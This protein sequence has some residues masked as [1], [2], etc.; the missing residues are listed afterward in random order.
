MNPL[1]FRPGGRPLT[2]APRLSAV[3]VGLALLW[4]RPSWSEWQTFSTRDGLAGDVVAALVEDRSGNL[5][6]GTRGGVSRYDGASWRTYT[7]ADGLA[8]NDVLAVLEDRSGNLWF[9]G[10]VNFIGASRYDGVSWRTY[11]RAD[12]FPGES[13]LAMLE[14][15]SG[16][17][18]FGTFGGGA[19][20]YDGV[21]WRTYTPADG[22]ATWF[23]SAIVEDRSSNLWFGTDSGV[24][25]YDGTSW[26]T[27]TTADGLAGN[28]I[29]SALV[30]HSGNVWFGSYHGGVSRWNG[31][32]WQTYTT[33]D[34]LPESP[35]YAIFEDRSGIL[36]FG[37]SDGL[38]RYDGVSWRTYTSPTVLVSVHAMIEDQSGN[39]WFGGNGG[40]IRYDGA[41][42]RTYTTS[43]GLPGN[44]V[45]AMLVDR[46][47]NLW[48]GTRG[49]VSRY[50][51]ASWRTYTTADGLASDYVGSMLEDHSGN[52][53]FGT[54]S[55]VSRYDGA[56]WRT[57]TTAD[58]LLGNDVSAM[59]ED[60]SG[61]LWF[62]YNSPFGAVTRWDGVSWRTYRNADGLAGV[63]LHAM[64]QDRSGNIWFATNAG[65]TRYDGTS[66]RTFTADDGLATNSVW[67]ILEDHSGNLWFG[68]ELG[69][70]RYDGVSWRTY[71]T[72]DGLAGVTVLAL[73]EDRSGTLWVAD[74]YFGV[75]R[76]DGVAWRALT[77]ADGLANNFVSSIVEDRF[78]NVWFGT[79][80]GGASAHAPDRVAPRAV[81]VVRP[82]PVAATRTLTLGFL[83]GFGESGVEFSNAFDGGSW[84]PWSAINTWT[85]E[86]M[87]D[88]SH[89]FVV[90]SR[91][92]FN[93][94]DPRP[95]QITFEVDAT[96]PSPVITAPVF[97][98]AIRDSAIIL[99]TA[100]DLRFKEFS[101]E[102]RPAGATSWNSPPLAQ[103]S[104]PVTGGALAGWNTRS[105]P[106]GDY[107]LRLSVADTL[108][109][110]GVALVS[111]QVDNYFPYANTTSPARVSAVAGGD[112]YTTNA[113][114]HLYVPPHAFGEDA[115][116]TIAP[117]AA[118]DV[119]DT[120]P[121][122]AQRVLSG[123][124]V[125]W[126]SA[127]LNK[128]ATLEL[129][130]AGVSAA[131]RGTLALYA[132]ADGTSWRRVGGTVESEAT[133]ISAPL[134][135]AGRY[136]LF[137]EPRPATGVGT[138]SALSV[139]P[140]VFSPQGSYANREVA[141]AFALGRSGPVS[142]TVFNRAGRLVRYVAKGESLGA[143][144]NLVR[145][146]GR[147]QNGA[148]VEDGI[149]LVT[150]EAL[151]ETRT[152]TL[153][154]VR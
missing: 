51:G 52:L 70:S 18:W 115:L 91:D 84:S 50:D 44:S 119:P 16:N 145:W 100:A 103:L 39:L 7:T 1:R 45:S 153:A 78:G 113:E 43:S 57:Y 11:G 99:G 148:L 10:G 73:L 6:F 37:T 13:V 95:P 81:L 30:D 26:R 63:L 62:G 22:L 40:A 132:S 71:R 79:L 154:T 114:L 146:D 55:G 68:T 29:S 76:Y 127:G 36:W 53:W 128:P 83:A 92:R 54:D 89:S 41:D 105:V 46:P 33:A 75:S 151:G 90:R 31:T 110:T 94:Q 143:G 20:R 3:L 147:D 150:V 19:S 42:W 121:S 17:L 5:W 118:H 86:N 87:T 135:D 69:L 67:A 88:G 2:I 141:I 134:T 125:S 27:Y 116:V 112:V 138:L 131:P 72:A 120:L 101:V 65:A 98:Q 74:H 28:G 142:V 96:P 48:F 32:N 139:T 23:V 136:A 64:L 77:T 144:A 14:D 60:R 80:G 133:R 8:G 152:L 93:N 25:R 4:P 108:G 49:G 35:V 15:H 109:L 85:G 82:P 24:S 12:G 66:W 117:L 126:G 149:Y 129:S 104:S 140:R 107:E 47:G 106:D 130:Y 61:N 58:G 123:Y 34:G 124:D 122:G 59:L 111:V 38:S 137:A 56:S 9:G 102:F 97:R 21:S